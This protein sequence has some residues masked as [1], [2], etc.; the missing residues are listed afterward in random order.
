[1]QN[2]IIELNEEEL[3]IYECIKN[4]HNLKSF[5]LFAGAG[6]GKNHSLVKILQKY[7][8]DYSQNLKSFNKQI[9]LGL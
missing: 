9:K 1:M 3:E 4:L 6:S 5:F 7:K 2:S 8:K